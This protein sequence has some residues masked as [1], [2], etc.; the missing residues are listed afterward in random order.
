MF[1]NTL[2]TKL[3][4]ILF[5]IEDLRQAVE[6]AKRILTKEK[7][8]RQLTRQSSSTPFMSIRDGHHR[9]VSFDTRE[10]LSD[11]IDKLAVMIGK[12]ATRDG[13]TNRQFKP[14]IH[15]SRG[16]GQN[17]NYNQRNYQN[18]YRSNNRSYSR[19]RGQ[20]RQAEVGLDMNKIIEEVILEEM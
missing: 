11:K 5:P 7:L 6:I 16:R 4:W 9:K 14:Q 1:K 10:E 19:D 13:G 8:D 20:Y 3:Y 15:Q 17:R 2:P 12:L 18:R